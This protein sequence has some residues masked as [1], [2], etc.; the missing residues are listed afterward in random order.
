MA[1]AKSSEVES[2]TVT[3]LLTPLN[4]NALPNFPAVDQVVLA[5]VP[6]FPLPEAS[7]TVEPVP[8]S[9]L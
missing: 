7:A 6:A 1:A 8:S 9:K 2:A 3:Q 5:T 4:D